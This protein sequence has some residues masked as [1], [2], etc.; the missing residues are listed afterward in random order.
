M[1]PKKLACL[2]CGEPFVVPDGPVLEGATPQVVCSPDCADLAAQLAAEEQTL[3][4]QLKQRYGDD[5]FNP[6]PPDPVFRAPTALKVRGRSVAFK[7]L[8]RKRRLKKA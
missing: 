5:V 1:K 2:G 8:K 3:R 7:G 4:T 6:T